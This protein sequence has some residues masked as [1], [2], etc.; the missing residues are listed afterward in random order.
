MR[1]RRRKIESKNPISSFRIVLTGCYSGDISDIRK[2]IFCIIDTAFRI[3][4]IVVVILATELTIS[5]NRIQGVNDIKSVG[6]L[7]PM[8]ISIGGFGHLLLA[9]SRV[10]WWGKVDETVQ[11]QPDMAIDATNVKREDEERQSTNKSLVWV[12]LSG[13]SEEEEYNMTGHTCSVEG[14]RNRWFGWI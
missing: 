3:A 7:I 13:I 8:A 11:C 9:T 1:F 2:G 10:K 12:D 4:S 14:R 5:W 6:Q